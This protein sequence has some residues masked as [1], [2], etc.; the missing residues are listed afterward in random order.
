MRISDWSSDVCSSDL[1][2]PGH[3][4][5]STTSARSPVVTT[6]RPGPL[7]VA[8]VGTGPAASYVV[9]ALL[10]IRELAAEVTVIERL[11]TPGG[12]I[13]HGV[14]PDHAG[15]KAVGEG[16]NRTLRDRKSKRLNSSHY[17]ATR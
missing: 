8:V 17:I 3:A 13:R 6:E 9:D 16:F 4:T 2:D 15:T 1:A 12:L 10:S 5:Y 11:L 14:A 7:R